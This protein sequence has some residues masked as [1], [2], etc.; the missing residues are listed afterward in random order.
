MLHNKQVFQMLVIYIVLLLF[1]ICSRPKRLSIK[2]W[3][4]L[5]QQFLVFSRFFLHFVDSQK[6][7][8]QSW[9]KVINQ[10]K[11]RLEFLLKKLK[12]SRKIV[13]NSKKN[14]RKVLEKSLQI[15]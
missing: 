13:E 9:I 14:S 6:S 11:N 8:K 3:L 12:N 5:M 15:R 4:D 2:N 1:K 7:I 10:L